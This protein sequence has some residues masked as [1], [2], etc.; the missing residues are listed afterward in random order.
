VFH[1]NVTTIV[2][3]LIFTVP[4]PTNG[5]YEAIFERSGSQVASAS[6]V[7]SRPSSVGGGAIANLLV[8]NFQRSFSGARLICSGM[9][10]ERGH[11]AR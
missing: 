7:V 6:V 8:N 1:F 11:I 9:W 5:L 3:E 4:D 10:G 2:H